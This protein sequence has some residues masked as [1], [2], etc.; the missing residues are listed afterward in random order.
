MAKQSKLQNI[1]AV[2]EMLAGKHKSQTKTHISYSGIGRFNEEDVIKFLKPGEVYVKETEDKD[3]K[4]KSYHTYLRSPS[5]Y[6][7]KTS[8][9][10]E[11]WDEYEKHREFIRFD[12]F[13]KCDK[14]NPTCSKKT[15]IFT[16]LDYKF[17]QKALMCTDCIQK[18]ESKY[19]YQGREVYEN[20]VKEKMI[21]NA[22]AFIA[23][24]ESE[25]ENFI[26]SIEKP[27]EYI[28]GNGEVEKWSGVN[29]EAIISKLRKEFNEFKEF[30]LTG[31][32]GSVEEEE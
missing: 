31:K 26:Q 14:D 17:A 24:Q 28:D 12:K 2:R 25:F 1:K 8:G 16:R 27:T 9:K 18:E 4:R 19:K 22:N 21:N 3:T 20:W 32:I 11:S 29:K 7:F 10:F 13:M 30:V 6:V 5:G 23:E 15:K